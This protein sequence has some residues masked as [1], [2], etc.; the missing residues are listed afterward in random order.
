MTQNVTTWVTLGNPPAPGATKGPERVGLGNSELSSLKTESTGRGGRQGRA[1]SPRKSRAKSDV[2]AACRDGP[3]QAL[4]GVPD[5]G[6]DAHSGFA[7]RV[8]TRGGRAAV[9]GT[10]KGPWTRRSSPASPFLGSRR[11]RFAGSVLLVFRSPPSN[12]LKTLFP[13][14]AFSSGKYRRPQLRLA[15]L[16]GAKALEIWRA[17]TPPPPAPPFGSSCGGH[18]SR[19]RAA[20]W[21]QPGP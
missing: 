2:R 13:R 15:N 6:R 17:T 10:R 3:R 8:H 14:P 20:C 7:S 21:K 12:S 9:P 19:R 1:R 18:V 11:W 16:P 4:E 5:A